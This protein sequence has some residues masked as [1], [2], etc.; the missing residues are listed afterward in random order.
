MTER[1]YLG[2]GS[3]L[4]DREA[5]LTGA[6]TALADTAGI[7]H[8]RC[9]PIYETAPVGPPGQGPYLN[10]AVELDT[11]L[12]AEPLLAVLLRIERRS[13]R[14]RSGVR[15]EARPLDLDLLFYGAQQIR[16]PALT[17]PHP[18]LHERAFVLVPLRDL[19]AGL[20][21]PVLGETV[22]SLATRVLEEDS[23]AA[24]GVRRWQAGS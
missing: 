18:R 12:G 5:L 9:S 14:R 17:V 10:A 7:C 23:A 21:H 19:A 22:A 4:G 11:D 3:N 8:V 16:L 1:A 2:V 6:L 15:N 13:G 20:R 24:A